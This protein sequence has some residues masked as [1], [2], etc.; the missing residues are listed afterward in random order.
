MI[1]IDQIDHLL[2]ELFPICRSLTG[3]GNRKTLSLLNNITPLEI[4]EVPSGTDVFDWKVPDE[5]SIREAWIK[6]EDG[7]EI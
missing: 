6:D 5:W 7:N 4:H 1:E 3:E 2:K